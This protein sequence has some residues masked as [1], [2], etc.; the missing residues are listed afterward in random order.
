MKTYGTLDAWNGRPQPENAR[1][2]MPKEDVRQVWR[3]ALEG[4]AGAP[5]ATL[6]YHT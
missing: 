4:Q 3:A 1:T 5:A 6:V 2:G